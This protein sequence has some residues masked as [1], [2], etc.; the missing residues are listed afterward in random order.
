LIL[1]ELAT[2]LFG[3]LWIFASIAVIFF[4]FA[5]LFHYAPWSR[6]FWSFGFS[7]VAK[8]L[9]RGFHDTQGR[10]QFVADGIAAGLSREEASE[11]WFAQYT[12]K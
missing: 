10:I 5:A 3:W 12:G 4:F 2:G 9:A 8:W 11:R 6:F 7:V 1:A